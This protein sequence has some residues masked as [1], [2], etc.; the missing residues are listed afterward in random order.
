MAPTIGSSKWHFRICLGH[1]QDRE[2]EPVQSYHSRVSLWSVILCHRSIPEEGQD[3]EKWL[4][5]A[6]IVCRRL[7]RHPSAYCTMM[8][9]SVP[10]VHHDDLITTSQVLLRRLDQ[11]P[12]ARMDRLSPPGSPSSRSISEFLCCTALA[13]RLSSSVSPVVCRFQAIPSSCL[14]TCIVPPSQRST[15]SGV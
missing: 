11:C 2:H 15:S 9:P 12:P 8:V 10:A 4:G 5:F 3:A 1:S 7:D 6:Q 13:R 14:K